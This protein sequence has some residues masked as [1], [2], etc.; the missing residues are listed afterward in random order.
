[1]DPDT[2]R[3]TI[4]MILYG[5]DFAPDLGDGSVDRC[6]DAIVNHRGF[7]DPPARFAGAIDAVL[8]DGRLSEQALEMSF[9]RHYSEA[10]LLDFL[11]RLRARLAALD[12]DAAVEPGAVDPGVG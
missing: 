10:E 3:G 8:R 1:V 12:P 7:R 5:I 2:V 9:H 11:R 6:A 4:N